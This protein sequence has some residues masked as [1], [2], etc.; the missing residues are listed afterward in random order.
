[1][2]CFGSLSALT[3]VLGSLVI[4]PFLLVSSLSAQ[5]SQSSPAL[6][7]NVAPAQEQ[8]LGDVARKIHKNADPSKAQPKVFDND[9]LPMADKISVVGQPSDA[10]N[11]VADS[12]AKPGDAT[13]SKP[14]SE[15]DAAKKQAEWKSW[16]GKVSAQ[17]QQ[18][19]LSS[20]ELDVL[21]RE[22]QLRAAEMYADAGNRLRNS[23][24]WDKQD[25][26]YKQQIADKQKSI[27]DAKQKLQDM[28]EQG[29][30]AGVPS[31][32]LD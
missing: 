25:A 28:Q 10:A 11:T 23:G 1:I 31:S 24:Q 2:T 15:D 9:N 14:A 16:Q 5:N 22:Y 32:M 12:T 29:R 18:I 4:G 3:F 7:Q 13:A 17:K 21:Q 26:D 6:T 8:P 19:D 20:R 30:K 27:D